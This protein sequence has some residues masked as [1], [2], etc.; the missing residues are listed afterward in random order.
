VAAQYIF[1]SLYELSSYL[2]RKKLGEGVVG[3]GGQGEGFNTY[4][5]DLGEELGRLG[6]LKASKAVAE[7]RE[8]VNIQSELLKCYDKVDHIY[9]EE[10]YHINLSYFQLFYTE[11]R[12][13]NRDE[14]TKVNSQLDHLV[15]ELDL[16]EINLFSQI[17]CKFEEYFA[18]AANFE[19]LQDSVGVQLRRLA[20]SRR[21]IQ[22]V[23]REIVDKS[24][25]LR[26]RIV[27]R[28]NIERTLKTIKIMKSIKKLPQVM[29]SILASSLPY[30][31]LDLLQQTKASLDSVRLLKCLTHTA[32]S[33]K[34]MEALAQ[35]DLSKRYSNDLYLYLEQ[36]HLV[37][38]EELWGR[39]EV[40]SCL[41]KDN[42]LII[43][44]LNSSTASAQSENEM[45]LENVDLEGGQRAKYVVPRLEEREYQIA[46]IL[47]QSYQYISFAPEVIKMKVCN[48]LRR[49]CKTF[50]KE[51]LAYLNNVVRQ[52]II[53]RKDNEKLLEGEPK[54]SEAEGE[55]KDLPSP[56]KLAGKR[57][58]EEEEV[59]T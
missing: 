35:N 21:R 36:C 14:R 26:A 48:A 20:E 23:K 53:A 18:V 30:D 56:S 9:F 46:M 39:L 38:L 57:E 32:E 45:I 15:E 25:T 52:E 6:K 7:S 43:D 19:Y 44:E 22:R 59:P 31:C 41:D 47:L 24:V 13:T 16:V 4:L 27:Q 12:S 55:T 28:Q 29:E 8:A 37:T 11:L 3:T 54:S 58:S 42:S 50:E 10:N 2:F 34:A 17:H 51:L 40:R 33:I 5:L 49:F 1:S